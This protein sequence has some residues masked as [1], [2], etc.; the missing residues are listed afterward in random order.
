MNDGEYLCMAI[1][2]QAMQSERLQKDHNVRIVQLCISE[3]STSMMT[4]QTDKNATPSSMRR[5]WITKTIAT[6]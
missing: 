3:I 6:L 2:Y 4:A 1:L 5:G